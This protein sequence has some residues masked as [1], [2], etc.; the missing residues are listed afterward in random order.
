MSENHEDSPSGDLLDQLVPIPEQELK[1]PS[2]DIRTDDR[3]LRDVTAEALEA[4]RLKNEPHELFQRGGAPTR[5]RTDQQDGMPT[6]ETLS[7]DGL[8]GVL[9]RI[10]TW[11]KIV[12]RKDGPPKVVGV[13]PP[14]EVVKDILALPGW[15]EA[16]FPTLDEVIECPT[17]AANGKLVMEPGYDPNSRL[18]YSPASGLV[19]PKAP[20][21]TPRCVRVRRARETILDDLLGDFPFE[22]QA[23]RANAL[24]LLLLPFIRPMIDGP[25]PLHLIEAA[26]PGTG[27][28]LLADV[29]HAIATGRPASTTAEVG[30]GEEWRKRIFAALLDCPKY[31]LID[32][33]NGFLNS[34]AL[35]S[36][37]T[38]RV[39][40][41]RILGTSKTAAI[42]VR[43]VWVGTGNNVRMTVEIA[44]RT[45]LIRLVAA[46][47]TP[48]TRPATD[49]HHPDLMAHVLSCRGE[50]IRAAVTLCQAW[51]AAGLPKGGVSVGS[52]ESWSRTMSGLLEVIGVP[53]FM[54][55][56]SNLLDNA[57]DDQA[58]WTAFVHLWWQE[59]QGQTVGTAELFPMIETHELLEGVLGDFNESSR[60]IKLGKALRTQRDAC[61]GGRKIVAA[62][63]GHNGAT[64]FRLEVQTG[65]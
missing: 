63:K 2:P 54:A 34:G 39:V 61:Y 27:K 42:P 48:W 40:K 55:N 12:S 14:V 45:P 24:A 25:T 43:C 35:A 26:K 50:L 5:L 3:Q 21:R 33:I 64:R 29:V 6:L 52:F 58:K 65:G 37:L 51:V 17:F 8:R 30:D 56:A 15:S 20:P 19:M 22:D 46:T 60:R 59:F 47:E 1:F 62:G 41:D 9:T 31:F 36:A 44:R 11:H 57:N 38:A 7:V 16:V 32:N 18:W 53:G 4:I 28:G 10:A 13:A 23:S 49:F